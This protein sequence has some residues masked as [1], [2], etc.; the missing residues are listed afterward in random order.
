MIT[1]PS[2][3]SSYSLVS[4]RELF[5]V[6]PRLHNDASGGGGGGGAGGG[7]RNTDKHKGKSQE[8]AQNVEGGA[9]SSTDSAAD[10]AAD[11][12][13]SA[14]D[15][16][17]PKDNLKMAPSFKTANNKKKNDGI[18][19]GTSRGRGRAWSIPKNQLP[20]PCMLYTLRAGAPTLLVHCHS[21]GC[22][23]GDMHAALH[24]MAE[25]FDS[26]VMS[27][28]FPGY[29][30]YEGKSSMKDID[31]TSLAILDYIEYVL[32][33]DLSRVIWYG[34]SI[35]SGPALN[36]AHT[37]VKRDI[38]PAGVIIQCGFSDFKEVVRFL[39]GPVAKSF[40]QKKWNNIGMIGE[41]DCPVLILHG[42]KDKM[43]PFTQAEALWEQVQLKDRSKIVLCRC[44]HNDFNFQKCTLRPINE[45]F[46]TIKE[47]NDWKKPSIPQLEIPTESR[48]RVEHMGLLRLKMPSMAMK[49]YS[50]THIEK[51]LE[52]LACFTNLGP[53]AS[54]L[55]FPMIGDA[56]KGS[57]QGSTLEILVESQSKMSGSPMSSTVV[58]P[59]G[60]SPSFI[61]D[62]GSSR[63]GEFAIFG[64]D[65][66]LA[67]ENINVSVEEDEEAVAL[68]ESLPLP[69]PKVTIPGVMRKKEKIKDRSQ[70]M[71]PS[72]KGD[73]SSPDG[74]TQGG[75]GKTKSSS[76]E[77]TGTGRRG[78][79][80]AC[81]DNSSSEM[82]VCVVCHQCDCVYYR[83][84]IAAD[85]P[86]HLTNVR[87]L[88]HLITTRL[89]TFLYALREDLE[90]EIH[91]HGSFTN[92]TQLAHV[93]D[94]VEAQFWLRDPML[95]LYEELV[96][97]SEGVQVEYS[98]GPYRL[99]HDGWTVEEYDGKRKIKN[100]ED[101]DRMKIPLW[102]YL[103][104]PV[105]FRFIT[106]WI[107]LSSSKLRDFVPPP[108]VKKSARK[109][110]DKEKEQKGSPDEFAAA[111]ATHFAAWTAEPSRRKFLDNFAKLCVDSN[112]A[113]KMKSS[114]VAG[115]HEDDIGD[116]LP[117]SFSR[118]GQPEKGSYEYWLKPIKDQLPPLRVL[119]EKEPQSVA[120]GAY[121]S[122][123]FS[124]RLSTL[125]DD[126]TNHSTSRPPTM[127]GVESEETM[128]SMFA[129]PLKRLH[130][131]RNS[132]YFS[133]ICIHLMSTNADLRFGSGLTPALNRSIQYVARNAI[134]RAAKA[135][136]PNPKS[137]ARSCARTE[138]SKRHRNGRSRRGKTTTAIGAPH[139]IRSMK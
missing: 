92:D 40:V 51:A 133:A 56:N 138:Y 106:E 1:F 96:W 9:S 112:R 102:C 68:D 34:R 121:F 6:E 62:T 99:R 23:I 53:N 43:I 10:S 22:D 97:T 130:L 74:K 29:G 73:A 118:D 128:V 137:N 129:N 76:K 136:I 64:N 101:R 122:E 90:A 82:E 127:P 69:M 28:D 11:T 115:Q 57:H 91:E 135:N 113:R 83:D 25:T 88:C 80:C 30:L 100:S 52:S 13:D 119:L 65:S 79:H 61:P 77:R 107:M 27:F 5:F 98:L 131:A 45:F 75:G 93:I 139:E 58:G 38:Q 20:I 39:F 109:M 111:F 60:R 126:T 95:T 117:F 8:G 16:R 41:L 132:D 19:R 37:L 44:G 48:P 108:I 59:D 47:Y 81:A 103:P 63:A 104:T 85:D 67:P 18:Y 123:V 17:T 42:R 2:P 110:N 33:V 36:L 15:T 125:S 50:I 24:C 4:H 3:P 70:T 32:K 7:P 86:E 46:T 84:G 94:W 35:G 26:H 78:L 14:A 89:I 12:S 114:R 120:L 54:Y 66:F 105:H 124:A 71:H 21:N 134:K 55:G 31:E 49:R 87:N 116:R 72:S